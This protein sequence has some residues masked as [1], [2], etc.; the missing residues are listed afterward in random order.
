MIKLLNN[1]KINSITKIVKKH[2]GNS[3]SE[4]LYIYSDGSSKINDS[5]NP[6]T[7]GLLLISNNNILFEYS[8]HEMIT[9]NNRMELTGVLI[10]SQIAKALNDKLGLSTTLVSDSQYALNTLYGTWAKKK[11]KD[12]F[13]IFDNLKINFT[14]KTLWIKGHSGNIFNEYA[15]KLCELEYKNIAY[16]KR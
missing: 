1:R 16:V 7:F 13:E 12:I 11:N 14:V 10:A 15:D 6:G 5:N 2:I 9:T 4:N 8:G 3:G